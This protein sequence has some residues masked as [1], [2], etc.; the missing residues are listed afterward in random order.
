MDF[1]ATSYWL[2]R[3]SLPGELNRLLVYTGQLSALLTRSQPHQTGQKDVSFAGQFC[4]I[5]TGLPLV[6]P[7]TF[8]KSKPN[9][10]QPSDPSEKSLVRVLV[11]G[12]VVMV[13]LL[14][15]LYLVM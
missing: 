9:M 14:A 1:A 8:G 2:N 3:S 7:S 10:T 4:R 13:A 11:I 15:W 12:L 6:G 5:C